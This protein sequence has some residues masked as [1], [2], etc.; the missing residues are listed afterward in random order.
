MS[1]R[2]PETRGGLPGVT[3][4]SPRAFELASASASACLAKRSLSFFCLK[5]SSL[6]RTILCSQSGC[7]T[8]GHGLGMCCSAAGMEMIFCTALH[9]LVV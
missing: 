2:A 8:R 6:S 7:A 3:A 4:P 1:W 5:V 9:N